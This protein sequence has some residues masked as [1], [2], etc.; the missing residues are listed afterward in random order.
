MVPQIEKAVIER[1]AQLADEV[2]TQPRK[3]RTLVVEGYMRYKSTGETFWDRI[4][5]DTLITVLRVGNGLLFIVD[6]V[7]EGVIAVFQTQDVEE[8]IR[9]LVAICEER[10]DVEVLSV[11]EVSEW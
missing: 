1:L 5:R 4:P 8:G 3:P 9:K 10:S 11:E 6:H 7:D 2:P